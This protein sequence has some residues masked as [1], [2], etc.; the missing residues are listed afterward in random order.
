MFVAVQESATRQGKGRDGGSPAA[1]TTGAAHTVCFARPAL[2]LAVWMALGLPTSGWAQV[3]A[4]PNAGANRPTIGQTGNGL[5]QV[6]ITRP[7]A[8]GVSTNAYTQFDVP[9]AGVILNNSPTVTATQQAGYI[10]GN[11]NLLPGGS[12]RIIVNQVTSTLPSQLRGYLEV[13]GPR[14]EVIV[15]NPNGILVDGAGFINTSRATL[16]TGGPVFGGSGSLDAFRVTGGQITV[17]GDGLNATRVDQVDLI[18]RAVQANGALY[19]DQLNVI[20]GA[21]QVSHDSLIATPIAGAAATPTVGIDVAQLGGMYANKILL[22]STEH[23]VGVS[24]RGV[25]AAQAGDLTLTT[26]GKLVLA[27]LTNA[28]G[29]LAAYARDG[30]ESTGTT[31]G[32]QGVSVTTDGV[33]SN[34]GTLAAQQWLNVM[35]DSVFST[36]TLAAGVNADGTIATGAQDGVMSG[37]I[38]G[39]GDVRL[40][41]GTVTNHGQVIALG[42]AT[43]DATSLDNA[44]G[45]IV[46]GGQLD[47]ATSGAISN[48]QGNLYGQSGLSISSSWLDNSGGSA[49]THGD[50]TVSATGAVTNT[51]GMLAAN[52]DH[53]S[54]SVA[55]ASVD[56]TLG[57]IGN[58]GDGATT[59][60][61]SATLTNTAGRLGGNGDVSVHAQTL[62]NNTDGTTGAL[63]AA[64]GALHLDVA[65]AVDNRSGSLYGGNGLTL[66]QAGAT[67]DNTGGQILGGTDVKL[68]VASLNNLGGA[69]R[70]NQDV[71]VAGAISGSGEMAA[72]HNLSL[73]IAGDYNNDP[74]NRL[75]A[76]GDML[77]SATGTLT[78]TGTLAAVGGLTVQ[79]AD[80][81][82]AAG[83][84]MNGTTTT[85]TAANA[86]ANAGRIEGDTVYTNSPS[87]INTGTILGNN[88]TVQGTD[89]MNHG[90]T[91]LM[92]AVQ[93]LNVYASDSVQNLDGA[94]LYSAGNLQIAR[95]GRRDPD[96]GLLIDQT[97]ALTNRSAT[98]EAEGDIDIAAAQ[99]S[100]TRTSIVTAPGTP[101]STSQTLTIW[102]AG[103]SDGELS[104]HT[105]I[106]FPGWT[107]NASNA[108]VSTP[109]T[110]ALRAPITVTVDKSTVTGLDTGKRTLSFTESPIEQYVGYAAAPNCDVD[111]GICSRPIATHPTQ[112][113][114]SIADNGSTYSITFWPDWDPNQHIRPDQVR[115]ENFG[116]DYNE[117]AR[118][119]V[120]TTATDQLISA[121]DPARIQAGGS[122]RIHS[123]GG[124]ILNQS[125]IMAAGE[126]LIRVAADGAVQDIGTALQQTVSTAESSTFYWHQRTGGSQDWQDVAY[127]S[128]P[129]APTTVMALP[130]IAS[131]NQTVQ[132]S[133][134]T[135]DVTT[136]NRSGEIV[137]GGGVSG[138]GAQD[139]IANLRLP[140]NDLY[141]YQSAPD[142]TYL[143]A[144][145]PRFTQYGTFLSSDYMLGQLGLDPMKMQKRLGDGFYEEKLIR[146][147]V[148]QLT[149]RTFLAGYRDNL[150]EYQALMDNGVAYASAFNLTPG[151][152]LTADQMA[153]LST[154][155]V[156]LVS[157]DVTLPDGTQQ[158]VLVP[159]LYLATSHTVDLQDSGALVTG[160]QVSLNA[161]GDVTNSGK[162]VGD[163]TTQVLGN[164]IVNRGQIGGTGTTVVQAQQ[165]VRNV[166]GRITGTDTLVTAGR[167]VI[168]A[169]QTITNTTTLSNGNSASATGVGAVGTISATNNIG[170]LAGR[171][172]S[173]A[174]GNVSAGKD[175]LLGAGRDLNLGTVATGTTQGASAH[176]GQDYLRDETT[177]G[178]GSSIEAGGNVTAVAGRDATLTSSV[179][180][181][182]GDAALV[183]GRN[184]TV[185]AGMDT[186]TH[187]AGAFSNQDSKFTQ[188][189]YDETAGGSAVQAGKNVTLGAG[190][191]ATVNKV[192]QANGITAVASDST[193]TGNLAV[194]GS[195]VTTD[196]GAATLAAPGDVMVGT[197]TE[198]HQ[199]QSWSQSSHSG[200]LSKEKTTT[201]TSEQ[202]TVAV[203][204]VVSADSVT[205]NAGH[206]LTV[207]GS[208]VAA[209]NDVNLGAGNNLTIGSAQSTSES[210]TF[211]ENTKTG[212]GATGNGISYGKRDQKDTTNDS[213]VTQ[214]ASLVGSTGGSLH[215]QAGNQLKVTGSELIAAKDVTGIGADVTIDASQGT[216]HHD[217]TH[218]VKQ[219]GF[220]LGV[221]GGA[222]GAAIN[223]GN[224]LSS[225]TKSQDGRASALWGVAAGRD[226]FDAGSALKDGARP[227]AGTTVTLSF[228]TSQSKQTFTEDSTTH[229]GSQVKAGGTTAFQATGKDQ[230]GNATAGNLNIVGS[231]IDAKNVSL[232]AKNDVNI[233]SATDTDESHSTNKSSSGS[234]GVSY[235]SQGSG[236]TASASKAK[237]NSDSNG[238]TQ[239]NSYVTGSDSVTI[240]SGNDTNIRGATV[241]GGKIWAD[242]GHD[243]S[244]ESRQDTNQMRA[245]QESMGGGF[246]ISQGGGSA[247][248]S[249]SNGKVNGNYANVGEQSGIYAGEGGF[250]INVKGNTDLKGAV[251]VSDATKDKNSL[252]TGTLTY[253]DIQNHSDY[254]ASSMGLS[255]GGAFGSPSGQSNSGPTSGKNTGGINP[256][257]PQSESGSQDGVA[258]SAVADGTINITNG[259]NQKQDVA[260]LSRDTSNTNTQVGNNPDLQNILSKQSDMMAAAQAAGEAVAKTVGD[261]ASSKR[262]Q[263]LANA[264]A[265]G[266]AGNTELQ[267]QYLAEAKSWEDGGANR[268]ALQAAGGALVAGLGAGNAML[269]AVGAGASSLAAPA[270]KDLSNSVADN[271]NMG[272]AE[273]NQAI[274]NIAA[275]IA[276]GGIGAVVAGGSGAAT[277]ANVDRFNRQ[278]H[279]DEK[280]LA[281]QIAANAA[282]RG[283]A[284]PDGSPITTDQIQNALR[285]ANNSKYGETSATGALVPLNANTKAS[286][287]Y[288]TTGMVVVND[289]AGHNSLMQDPSVLATPSQA[290]Q[291]LITQNTGGANSQ[292]SWNGPAPDA[293][294]ST[295]SNPPVNPFTPAP[296]GC[297]T[298]ECAAGLGQQ[299]RGLLPDYATG[300]AAVLSGSSSATINLYD[301]TS[302]VGG[303]VTQNFPSVSWK[304]GVTG[305]LGWIFGAN[306]ANAAN[307]FL[308]GDGNQ[309]FV[310]I[311]TPF[312]FNVVGAVTHAYGGSTAIE[313]GLGSPGAIGFGVTPW[314]HGVPV[315]NG[316]K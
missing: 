218:E 79:A 65:T 169:S 202:R 300:G 263:A 194:L 313:F 170:V 292:Y 240:V 223:A 290:L 35:G 128:T 22:A 102:Q 268:A 217:E 97:N 253:S 307:S 276:A 304:P 306:D 123:S 90:A 226:A 76:D 314:S 96:T 119:T 229:T 88:V 109:Q 309:A 64:G 51:D 58:S 155:M 150:T 156:W 40:T 143:I 132:T 193:G 227:L 260:G 42:D 55:G 141:H 120:T 24:L 272:N 153:Q 243:L 103:L 145:D 188:S 11:P 275:N 167:D 139:V 221:S 134:Q 195:A 162:L 87:I 69:I 61:A 94:T 289:G 205:A 247:S 207:S 125:S 32:T 197:V 213:S 122:I 157:Q 256:M 52:G 251:I 136:V 30:I 140:T 178:A 214:T 277:A 84:E 74:A 70:A 126:D 222:I 181:A 5:P 228:G 311:P 107:W 115:Q 34:H 302:Y 287:I 2:G 237:G 206:D 160:S 111:M 264:V 269:G 137:T 171:D 190:Q 146:D 192:L 280:T 274:G 204:S 80:V 12:A 189:S 105:S 53:G 180:A 142:A 72:G 310:S 267:Q 305:T 9:R 225:A 234:I 216:Q 231:N 219:S 1:A 173:M 85:V 299:G 148:T 138:G 230:N 175:A 89:V 270:L 241:S 273:L 59:V 174:G 191:S 187:N 257:I 297:I 127:P 212:F 92:A 158:T 41:A 26:Q 117:I 104:H 81:V 14:S 316:G 144:T 54:L 8:A 93:N 186:H 56:N 239:T 301:G 101:T 77:V 135:I 151:I 159:K 147:Q 176:G 95:D 149:G 244:I 17:Q 210:H 7:S 182:G 20:A 73:A 10:N 233:V 308:N 279:P 118:T 184:T 36:G 100:N 312:E 129:Q 209:T 261:V 254:S 298:P 116:H 15:A 252:T 31:Y 172:I 4:D 293:A 99:V 200:L 291:N 259:A 255:A 130:A 250:D 83:A 91:A 224:K 28:S 43:I 315:T 78:N 238:T 265:A 179:V 286:Q 198:N 154:D 98:I 124:N 49:Q 294:T 232:E 166:G 164:N 21:N 33:L 113:Y 246:S 6:D 25:A 303:G 208:T 46:A 242:V 211:T 60:T 106:T 110:E 199:S 27:G 38:G 131:A 185:T 66:D 71:A 23:G 196:K 295:A 16:T 50:L 3:V 67:L 165:D 48:R 177:A 249:A 284:N 245:S 271:I 57:V 108:Q 203:G 288:D 220:T 13:A 282:A 285:S 45:T 114:Q 47:V 133:A 248:F 296:N 37:L 163:L 152:G 44:A 62:A 39:N 29:N 68:N 262:D 82:N 201:E 19:A 235:G 258:R 183:A 161:S 168:N 112:Y 278:L 236:L 18:A 63:L 215:M 75:R 281:R 121:S 86:L 283:L 266:Q